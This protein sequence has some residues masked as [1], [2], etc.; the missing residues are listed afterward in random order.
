M[1]DHLR[2]GKLYRYV[3]R[4]PGQ[5]SLA[6]PLWVGTVSTSLGWVRICRSGVALVMRHTVTDN[7]GLSTCRLNG[8]WKV[9][10]H[11]AF[12]PAEYG[13]FTFFI[14]VALTLFS[15]PGVALPIFPD[16]GLC[17]L[18]WTVCRHGSRLRIENALVNDTG[19]YH[20]FAVNTVGRSRSKRTRVVVTTVTS[21]CP[22]N[23][24]PCADQHYCLH[25]GLCC[26]ID[27]LAVKFCQ[28]VRHVLGLYIQNDVAS[29]FLVGL[30]LG[31]FQ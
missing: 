14:R 2:A 27:M 4:H 20:C 28:Y 26:Q 23:S 7:S 21:T 18:W 25:G 1:G 17:V 24:Q 5:L 16:L 9:D 30:I 11:P 19:S 13:L 22:A 8:L 15:E 10:E 12:T 6:I 31:L 29:I 3:T